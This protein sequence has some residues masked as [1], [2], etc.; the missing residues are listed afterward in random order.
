MGST[1]LAN[2]SRFQERLFRRRIDFDNDEKWTKSK[3][4]SDH[5]MVNFLD[6]RFGSWL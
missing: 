3:Q 6:W 2:S 1:K 5:P 4:W